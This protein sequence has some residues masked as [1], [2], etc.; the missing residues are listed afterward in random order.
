MN[1]PLVRFGVGL[2]LYLIIAIPLKVCHAPLWAFILAA[3][4]ACALSR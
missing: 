4:I 2:G 1:G 3:A